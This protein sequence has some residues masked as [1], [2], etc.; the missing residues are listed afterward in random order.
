GQTATSAGSIRERIASDRSQISV[1]PRQDRGA[2]G[3]MDKP[4]EIGEVRP[5]FRPEGS[6]SNALGNP[7]PAPRASQALQRFTVLDLTRVRS[8][9]TCVRQLAD[10]GA[11]VIKIETPSH[12]EGPGEGPGGP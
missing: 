3:G 4:A 7:M 11:N 10:W 1:Q 5:A 8:G 12:L 6:V 9:P 2:P